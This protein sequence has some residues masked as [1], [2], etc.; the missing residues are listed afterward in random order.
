MIFSNTECVDVS[1]HKNWCNCDRVCCQS[2]CASM[3]AC[4][5]CNHF[6]NADYFTHACI[7]TLPWATCVAHC[8]GN[9]FTSLLLTRMLPV[10]YWKWWTYNPK[11][12]AIPSSCYGV[13]RKT[14]S[15]T[16]AS[17]LYITNFSSWSQ[18]RFHLRCLLHCRG[19]QRGKFTSSSLTNCSASFQFRGWAAPSYFHSAGPEPPPL[20]MTSHKI[21]AIWLITLVPI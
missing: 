7:A 13:V 15:S 18:F 8:L 17:D 19:G 10:L 12:I 9:S 6:C 21:Y 2:R 20:I 3:L 1:K 16:V 4:R 11:L 5:H 14:L